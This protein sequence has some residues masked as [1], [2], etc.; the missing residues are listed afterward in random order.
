M[1]YLIFDAGP[2]I[3]MTMNGLLPVLEKLKKEFKGE[4]IITPAVKKEIIDRPLKIKKFKLEAMQVTDLY[5]R[6]IF[7]PSSK[8]VPNTTLHKESSR[9]LKE[10][11]NA[12]KSFKTHE[13]IKLLHEGEASCMAFANLCKCDNVIVIDER[14]TRVLIETPYKLKELLERK[15]KT[16][17][18]EINDSLKKLKH[19][20]FIRSAELLY[21][22][23]KKGLLQEKT[24]DF[25]EAA[26][27]A[28]KFKGTAISS[29][30]I[31]Q[32]KKLA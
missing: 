15:I 22:A 3:S 14:T 16:E 18:V 4:F 17:I 31:N 1:K 13:R 23:Y 19:Q 9:I 27:F 29:S 7:T 24:K 20:K 11:N 21:V 2:V 6:G 26:L 5:N 25:L 32:I 10:V 8:I 12:L 28:V 30:E